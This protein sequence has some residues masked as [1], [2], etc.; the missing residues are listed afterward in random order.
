MVFLIFGSEIEKSPERFQNLSLTLTFRFL[1]EWLG[2]KLD[3]CWSWLSLGIL[4]KADPVL[5]SAVKALQFHLSDSQAQRQIRFH[6]WA[7]VRT[8]QWTR[9]TS[10]YR[11]LPCERRTFLETKGM[12]LSAVHIQASPCN[13]T[14][15]FSVLQSCAIPIAFAVFLLH[16]DIFCLWI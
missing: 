6:F 1:C 4:C 14:N 12:W 9:Q 16:Y 2:L 11:K 3:I 13:L 5:F 10:I 7:W 15:V 8:L